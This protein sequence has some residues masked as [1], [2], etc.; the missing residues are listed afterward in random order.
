MVKKILPIIA[1]AALLGGSG[2]AAAKTTFVKKMVKGVGTSC[3]QT[4]V[5]NRENALI[6]A[7]EKRAD[8]IKTAL[9]TR[10]TALI[11]AW[12]KATVKERREAR[13]SAWQA[14]QKSVKTARETYQQE[15]RNAW[16]TFAKDSKTCKVEN[17][18]ENGGM[19]L[20]L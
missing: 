6:A 17:P 15:V 19:D 5:E 10:K 14:F 7:Y 9:E 12:G 18:G 2:V 3:M 11:A 4:V 8:A 1:I 16:A 20:G 13:N